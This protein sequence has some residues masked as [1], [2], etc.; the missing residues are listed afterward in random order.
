M[1]NLLTLAGK[2]FY[3]SSTLPF[4]L[5][6]QATLSSISFQLNSLL[7]CL[8]ANLIVQRSITK[9]TRV[10][11][12]KQNTHKHNTKKEIYIIRIIIITIAL[13]QMKVIIKNQW[14]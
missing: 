6:V 12:K 10:N 11:E 8:S 1:W 2:Y 14:K 7:V 9:W 3:A 13:T 4:V 5:H